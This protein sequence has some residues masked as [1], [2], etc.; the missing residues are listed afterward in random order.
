MIYSGRRLDRIANAAALAAMLSVLWV[1]GTATA[2][3]ER[4]GVA[5]AVNPQAVGMPP[6]AS[7]RALFIGA[8]VVHDERIR[9]GAKGRTQVV[10]LDGSALTVGPNADMVIDEFIYDPQ[11]KAGSLALTATKGAFRFVGGRISKKKP[12]V[13]KTPTAVIGIR[14]GIAMVEVGS[15]TKATFLYGEQMQVTAGNVTRTVAQPGFEVAVMADGEAPSA[16]KRAGASSLKAAVV[17]LEATPQSDTGVDKPPVDQDVAGT[18]LATLGSSRAPQELQ[19]TSTGSTTGARAANNQQNNDGEDKPRTEAARVNPVRQ[20]TKSI[21]PAVDQLVSSKTDQLQTLVQ[22]PQNDQSTQNA[23]Q[24]TAIQSQGGQ[25]TGRFK[26]SNSSVALNGTLDLVASRNVGFTQGKVGNNRFSVGSLLDL[27]IG[28]PGSVTDFF[29]G[30]GNSS[31]GNVAGSS[32]FS[33]DGEF[34][35][36]DLR[37]LDQNG[38]RATAFAG[39]PT[40]IS[41]LPTTGHTDFRLTSDFVLASNIAF[42]PETRGGNIAPLPGTLSNDQGIIVWDVSGAPQA[43]RAVGFLQTYIDGSGSSQRSV[44]SLLAGQVLTDGQGRPYIAGSARGGAR[45][46]DGTSFGFRGDF[47]STPGGNGSHI[48]GTQGSLYFGLQSARDQGNGNVAPTAT[49]ATS[50]TGGNTSYFANVYASTSAHMPVNDPRTSTTLRGFAAGAGESFD[51]SGNLANVAALTTT[52]GN[53]ANA[54]IVTDAST[55]KIHG[56]IGVSSANS[57]I[58]VVLP[59]GDSGASSG[60]SV[61]A[62]DKAFGAVESTD[63]ASY[64]GANAATNRAYLFNDDGSISNNGLLPAGT[65]FCTCKALRWGFWGNELK[66]PADLRRR[67]HLGTWVAGDIPSAAEIAGQTGSATY[68]GHLIGSVINGTGSAAQT[69]LAVGNLTVSYDFSSQYGSVTVNNF[70]GV[71]YSGSISKLS[72]GQENRLTGSI[73]SASGPTRTGTMNGAFFRSNGQASG[74]MGGDVDIEQSGG[75]YAAGGTFAAHR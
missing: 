64:N 9:T 49:I 60:R 72:T 12:V 56:S 51:A 39:I 34:V 48:F 20:T 38:S 24:Q 46:G 61:F 67:V 2:A 52:G 15:N 17:G 69:Y 3:T 65:S 75:G 26:D 14:G 57:S 59:F 44:V 55:N 43:Q 74:A 42:L 22:S 4:I 25:F 35:T 45:Y 1:C 18:Q 54:F 6:G 7:D 11:V 27:P 63:P 33:P 21:A 41:A 32:H 40:P 5:A 73:Y 23:I 47:T 71:N 53:P 13:I 31:F 66:T 62:D 29:A 58:A 28:S 70:D 10:F 19:Q 30:G 16:P 37:L 36:F 8:N 68:Q 50:N